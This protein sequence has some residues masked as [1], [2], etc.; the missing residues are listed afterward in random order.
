M[1]DLNYGKG[2][3]Y[4]HDSK[5]KITAMQCLPDSLA[6]REYYQ[7]TDQGLEAR[8]KERLAHIKEWKRK[9]RETP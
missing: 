3:H 5:E 2:Y 9:L 4:A 6:D 1:K 8:F 7:P